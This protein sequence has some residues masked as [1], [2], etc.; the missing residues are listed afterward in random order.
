MGCKGGVQYGGG[1]EGCIYVWGWGVVERERD[2]RYPVHSLQAWQ[3]CPIVQWQKLPLDKIFYSWKQPGINVCV[4]IIMSGQLQ[5]SQTSI[6]L[7]CWLLI[8]PVV[9]D[10]N[11]FLMSACIARS[12]WGVHVLK[13]CSRR[14]LEEGLGLHVCSSFNILTPVS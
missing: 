11:S 1:G 6:Q 4:T 14:R 3:C 10:V 13:H 5:A 9:V 2:V 7:Q 8:R 12:L